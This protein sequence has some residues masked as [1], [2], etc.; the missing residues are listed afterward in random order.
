MTLEKQN[1]RTK[2]PFTTPNRRDNEL[3]CFKCTQPGHMARDCSNKPFCSYCQRIGHSLRSCFKSNGRKQN[4]RNVDTAT[5]DD[6]SDVCTAELIESQDELEIEQP[7]CSNIAV[8]SKPAKKRVQYPDIVHKWADY[9]NNNAPKP[10]ESIFTGCKSRVAT[11]KTLISNSNSEP[12][13]NKPVV[14]CSVKDQHVSTLFDTG[15]EINVVDEQ[16]FEELRK[17]F[18]ALK[19]LRHSGSLKCANA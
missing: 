13:A 3:K 6:F 14:K 5:D 18:P 11:T 7:E 17:K 10:K 15:A 19:I 4:I 9:V 8:V 16:F 2:V 12:A 1:R